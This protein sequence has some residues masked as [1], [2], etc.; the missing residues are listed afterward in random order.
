MGRIFGKEVEM[1]RKITP[2]A[3]V[4]ILFAVFMVGTSTSTLLALYYPD[5]P[6]YGYVGVLTV[7]LLL[8]A[9]FFLARRK[10]AT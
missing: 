1:A 9:T 3:E 10:K 6:S 2:T 4:L 7:A 8:V 5:S